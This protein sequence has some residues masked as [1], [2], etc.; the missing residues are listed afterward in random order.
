MR[1]TW[2][3]V[4]LLCIAA[5]ANRPVDAPFTFL[6]STPEAQ[7]VSS[8]ALL[9]FVDEAEQRVDALHSVMVVRHGKVVAE[10]WWEPYAADEPHMLF[11]LSKS[12]TSTAVGLAIADGKLTLDDPVLQFFPE[13]APANPGASLK[14]M[15]I[16]DLLTMS[17]GHHDEDIRDFPFSSSDSL[18]KKF[19]SLPVSHKPGTF[20][21]Y[22]TPASYML[23]AIVQKVTGQ[24]VVDYLRPRLFEPLGIANPTW[25]ASKQGV[26]M[27]GFGLSVGTED[28]ARF[29]QLY[30]QKGQ[31]LGKQL[32]P[33]E[34]VE[35][36]TS[37]QMS[38]GSS[39]SSDW[40]QGYGYQFW[41]C[42]HGF[43]RGDGAHGQFCIVMPQYDTVV[44]I[45]S[46]TR[47][48]ASV[49]NVVWDRLVPALGANPLPADAA[50]S[51][52]LKT[53]L[54]TLT[55]RPETTTSPSS[56]AKSIAG[57]RYTFATNRRSIEAVTF[58]AID[59][60]GT[61]TVTMRMNGTDQRLR[62]KSYGWQTG[63]IEHQ[64]SSDPVAVSG[65]WAADD[66]YVLKIVRYRTP[67]AMTYRL[68]F[69]GDQVTIDSEENVGGADTRLMTVVGTAGHTMSR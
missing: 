10:G 28:I 11:S 59:A 39:P 64:G 51:D 34:W 18:V 24:T 7:G 53:R 56:L 68:R 21:V 2:I 20:F 60:S 52:K 14:A 35:A 1:A 32:V 3:T 6:R 43:Y 16:R 26:S 57:R 65:G 66:T 30:L 33:A 4:S 67:F 23:S 62:A 15:R 5:A 45:T 8:T 17:T 47:D 41:R 42:R 22:N 54:A 63:T 40:E 25:E 50:S 13:D 37:R 48:M 69:A 61:A 19:L 9:R 44:A 29:G 55:L 49:M 36:A 58:D 27:G 38:N 46:G 31:W 12:F